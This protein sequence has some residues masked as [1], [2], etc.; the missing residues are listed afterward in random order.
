M[1][2]N[3]DPEMKLVIASPQLPKLSSK[4]PNL[5]VSHLHVRQHSM[6]THDRQMQSS[7]LAG[8][9]VLETWSFWLRNRITER[10]H[11]EI[12]TI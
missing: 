8:K 5:K 3:N 11:F 12:L 4:A 9:F 6:H 1:P 7:T 2:T 10:Q